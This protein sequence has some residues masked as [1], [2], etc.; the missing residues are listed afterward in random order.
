MTPSIQL[1][2]L[3]LAGTTVLDPGAVGHCLQ[4]ALQRVGVLVS[5]EDTSAVMGLP[6]PEAIRL[7]LEGANR[8][9]LLG[10]VSEIH[11]DFHQSMIRYY[12]E[13]PGVQEIP[14]TTGTFQALREA[15]IRI[16][17]DTGFDREIASVLLD[18]L[19]WLREGLVDATVTSDEVPHGRPHPDMIESLMT[20][21]GVSDPKTV[22]KVGDTPS[23][24]E[25]GRRAGCGWVIGVTTGAH[26]REQLA[27]FHPTHI[28]KSVA[29]LPALLGIRRGATS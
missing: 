4:A 21:L 20:R 22:V 6:K 12:R 2:V 14:G 29:E 28:L 25:E 26:R 16:A 17:L 10:R 13:D 8:G 9:E 1:V 11:D 18:R 27:A 7:L 19:D 23:D 15:G 5:S 3:D 24:V